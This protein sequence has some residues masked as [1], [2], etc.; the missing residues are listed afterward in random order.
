MREILKTKR[1]RAGAF[2][3]IA[4]IVFALSAPA[5]FA[6][7]E[8]DASAPSGGG[9]SLQLLS[10]SPDRD[11]TDLQSQ[12]VGIKLYFNGDVTDPSVREANEKS[13]KFTYKSGSKVK[14]LPIK[15]Y[16]A[17]AKYGKDYILAFVNTETL[18]NNMLENNKEYHLVISGD[19]RSVDGKTLGS[20]LT[21]DFKTADQSGSTQIYMLLM[22]GMIGAMIAMTIF[23]NKRKESAAAEVAAKAGRVNP[24]KLAK[25]KKISVNEAMELIERDRQKR[26][27]RLGIS[28]GKDET[29]AS[30]AA[31]KPRN[32]KKVKVARPI[33]AAGSGYKTGRSALVEKRAKEAAEKAQKTQPVKRNPQNAKA[34][35]KSKRKSRKK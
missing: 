29:E 32:T 24:Y 34:K 31:T 22:V 5:V 15:T 8:G 4:L 12:T 14:D 20:D 1:L 3:L 11:A 17:P 19:F 18:N 30:A 21:L 27:K 33:S 2:L 13:M 35:S 26:L 23:Q 28:Q 9:G 7:G 10:S 6:A 25:E 16:A